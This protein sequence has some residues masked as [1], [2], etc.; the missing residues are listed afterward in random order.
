MDGKWAG[1][2]V[3]GVVGWMVGCGYTVLYRGKLD[4]MRQLKGHNRTGHGV[5]LNGSECDPLVTS[6]LQISAIAKSRTNQEGR[7]RREIYI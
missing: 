6:N 3:S 7:A 4:W 5:Y 1:E 2:W